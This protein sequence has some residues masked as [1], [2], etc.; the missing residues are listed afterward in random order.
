MVDYAFYAGQYHGDAI[1]VADFSRFA[2]D[3]DAQLARYKRIYTVTGDAKAENMAMCAMA[4]ALQYFE[5]AANGG[6]IT[7]ASVGSVSSSFQS[8]AVPDTSPAA[9]EAELYRCA[10]LYLELYRGVGGCT[11]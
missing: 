7:G 4:E 9:R 11:G 10:R 8:G 5:A 6:V 3:A 1:P 2:R